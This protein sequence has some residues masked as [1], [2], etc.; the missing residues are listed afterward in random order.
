RDSL[1]ASPTSHEGFF[2]TSESAK[3]LSRIERI[4]Y[5]C[6]ASLAFSLF[7]YIGA[8][9]T[10]FSDPG[11]AVYRVIEVTVQTGISYFL[12][13]KCGLSSAISFNL[14][15]WT[16]GDDIAYYGWAYALNPKRP[17]EGRY[18]NGLQSDG[19]SWAGWT[20]IGL[21][22]KQKSLIDKATLLTQAMIG[23]SISIA[24]L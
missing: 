6:G 23:F 17:W 1:P 7:D 16:W 5:V 24:I 12:Y 8:N 15:W 18:Y 3:H 22:R 2:E 14:I 11:R 4:G 13:K 20:P 19:I 9:S 10:K 21:T